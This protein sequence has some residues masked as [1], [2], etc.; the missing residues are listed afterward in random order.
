MPVNFVRKTTKIIKQILYIY[1]INSDKLIYGNS[2]A[3]FNWFK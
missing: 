3:L 2:K 1:S